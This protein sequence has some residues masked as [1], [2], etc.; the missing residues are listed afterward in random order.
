MKNIHKFLNKQ[1]IPRVTLVWE[2]LCPNGKLT[3]PTMKGS[4]SW[5]ENLKILPS[6]KVEMDS[7]VFYGSDCWCDEILL[8]KLSEL[9]S[10]AT[11]KAIFSGVA[12][13]VLAGAMAPPM[14]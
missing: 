1:D 9:Y 6:Y 7:P 10:F 3:N 2:K 5:R 13:G 11:N 12:R 8:N 4:F 14:V